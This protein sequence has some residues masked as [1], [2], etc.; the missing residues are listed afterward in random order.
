MRYIYFSEIFSH[1]LCIHTIHH[2][3]YRKYMRM[4]VPLPVEKLFLC[5]F[6]FEMPC[7]PVIFWI[8]LL[9]CVS[10]LTFVIAIGERTFWKC[11]NE[12][13]WFKCQLLTLDARKNGVFSWRWE[14][15]IWFVLQVNNNSKLATDCALGTMLTKTSCLMFFFGYHQNHLKHLYID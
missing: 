10:C 7:E 15:V 2:I 5:V 13:G 12:S 6:L 14:N 8:I 3:A 9:S 11:F 4:T 1:P